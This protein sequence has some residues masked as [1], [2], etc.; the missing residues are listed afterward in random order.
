M[1]LGLEKSAGSWVGVRRGDPALLLF[2]FFSYPP[3]RQLRDSGILA[4]R[5]SKRSCAPSVRAW[6]RERAGTT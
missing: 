4:T 1:W 2:F 5:W 3:P 6:V